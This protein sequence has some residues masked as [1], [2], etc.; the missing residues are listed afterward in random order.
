M[1]SRT[2]R[3][4]TVGQA[5]ILGVVE[6]LTEYLPVSSTGHLLLAERLMGVGES[7]SASTEEPASAPG[8]RPIAY[9]IC[10]QAGAIIAVLGLY[11]RRVRQMLLGLAG[12]DPAGSR[13][14]VNVAAGFM[15]AAVIGLLFKP[16]HQGLS[17]R[18]MAG[19]GR[20]VR[21]RGSPSWRW[22][23]ITAGAAGRPMRGC[24]LKN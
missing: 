3:R 18:A 7:R 5:I 12:R 22:V 11:F 10:I 16:G 20:L 13:L 9:T 23:G 21:G 1:P 15:P 17:F 8:M 4:W 2:R 14:L 19:G 6:G 24:R